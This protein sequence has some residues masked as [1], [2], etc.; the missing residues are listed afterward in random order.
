MNRSTISDAC[1]PTGLRPRIQRGDEQVAQQALVTAVFGPRGFSNEAE[2][3]PDDPAGE[4]VGWKI[5]ANLAGS[6]SSLEAPD[7]RVSEFGSPQL[8]AFGG[9][10][11]D[12]EGLMF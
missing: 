10:I 2:V 1:P 9:V 4:V 6:R 5:A 11:S 7:G 8:G 3:D 12:T